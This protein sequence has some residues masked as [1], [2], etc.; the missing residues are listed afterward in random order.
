VE[1]TSTLLNSSEVGLSTLPRTSLILCLVSVALGSINLMFIYL[2]LNLDLWLDRCPSIFWLL[3]FY[4]MI[5]I[6]LISFVTS[7]V[8]YLKKNVINKKLAVYS[9]IIIPVSIFLWLVLF[10]IILMTARR[11]FLA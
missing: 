4:L 5:P 11:N 2:Q 6:V 10:C 9:L 8:A 3:T 1:E 7:I